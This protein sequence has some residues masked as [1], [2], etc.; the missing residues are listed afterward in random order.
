MDFLLNDYLNYE[1]IALSQRR[2]TTL[3][4]IP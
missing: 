2:R 1:I 4:S 3:H